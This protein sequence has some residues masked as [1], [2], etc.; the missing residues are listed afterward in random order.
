MT[1]A[2]D[3][4]TDE[5]NALTEDEAAPETWE[6]RVVR[7]C[8]DAWAVEAFWRETDRAEGIERLKE[9]RPDF[10]NRTNAVAEL[11]TIVAPQLAAPGAMTGPEYQ[12]LLKQPMSRLLPFICEQVRASLARKLVADHAVSKPAV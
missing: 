7:E 6:D 11:I 5:P 8:S 4:L 1:D 9:R 2:K 10:V 12:E 3:Q